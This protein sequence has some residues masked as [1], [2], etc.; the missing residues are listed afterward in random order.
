MFNNIKDLI[1]EDQ[2]RTIKRLQE[3]LN[4][5]SDFIFNLMTVIENNAVYSMSI[6]AE[7]EQQ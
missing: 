1:I 6:K 4:D 3:E 2:R 5:K 7:S